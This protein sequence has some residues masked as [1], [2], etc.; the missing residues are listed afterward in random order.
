MNNY[1]FLLSALLIAACT[2]K[3]QV[4]IDVDAV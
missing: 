3:A 1:C 4:V 2:E